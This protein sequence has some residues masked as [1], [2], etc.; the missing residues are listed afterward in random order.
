[1][2]L[3]LRYEIGLVSTTLVSRMATMDIPSGRTSDDLFY[4]L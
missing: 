3:P 2:I 4:S 1:M